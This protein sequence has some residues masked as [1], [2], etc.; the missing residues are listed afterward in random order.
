MAE[1]AFGFVGAAFAGIPGMGVTALTGF[2]IGVT[3]GSLLF[4]QTG[5]PLDKGKLDE[6]RLQAAQQGTPIPIIYGRNRTAGTVLWASGL[7]ETIK[8]T[9]GGKGGG[10]PATNNYTY[11]TSMA[12]LVCEGPVSKI[13]RIWA[14]T[15][16]IY[17]WRTGGSPTWADWIDPTKVKIYDGTQTLPDPTIEAAEGAGNVPAFMDLCY[18]VF[19]DLP[20]A[21]VGNQIPNFLFEVETDWDNLEDVMGDVCQRSGLESTDY[22]FSNLS[23]FPTRG[24][25]IGARTEGGRV[26]EMVG[27]ANRFDVI[28]S[29]GKIKALERSGIPVVDIPVEH[30]GANADGPPSSFVEPTRGQETDIPRSYEVKY[31]SEAQ[32][33]QEFTQPS[34]R[35]LSVRSSQNQESLSFPMSLEDNY[36]KYLADSFLLERWHN[37][38][39]YMLT[40]PY[41][42]LYLDAGDVI[43]VPNEAGGRD[44][45]RIL[46][47]SQGVLAQIEVKATLDDPLL[48]VDP[49][50]GSAG[51]PPGTSAGVSTSGPATLFARECNAL[52]DAQADTP[53]IF[54]A[55]GR[56]SPSWRGGDAQVSPKLQKYGGAYQETIATFAVGSDLGLTDNTALGVLPDGVVGSIDRVSTLKVAM[57]SGSLSSVTEAEMIHNLANMAVVGDEVIQFQTATLVSGSTYTLSNLLRGRRGTEYA[58]NDHVPSEPFVLVNERALNYPYDPRHNG[59]AAQFR[60]I[61]AS[62]DYSGGLPPFS[63][64]ILLESRSRKPYGPV[65]L[66]AAGDRSA[67]SVDVSLTWVR[68]V[69]KNGDLQSL[70]DAPLDEDAE[71]YEV[72]ILDVTATTILRTI[73]G[74]TA[75]THTY[76]VAEQTADGVASSAFVFR[77]YQITTWGGIGRGHASEYKTVPLFPLD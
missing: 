36:A 23:T 18:V 14:N 45:V 72:E 30:I 74:L 41:F 13:R 3:L 65:H 76:S 56:S 63:G 17:D 54:L 61:E 67:G 59:A 48:Y 68:R 34:R 6:I 32:D 26:S 16:V 40:L 37:R 2:Q 49:G 60:L 53:Q 46:E 50:L 5:P 62:R 57:I 75:P 66:R 27:L 39:G 7:K 58:M 73:T 19:E 51:I 24:I 28:E 35:S 10:S 64:A 21:E 33:F 25:V 1:L 38:M 29:G 8:T 52:L 12:L 20:L 9:G 55:A 4:P 71:A 43:T 69:R 47:M 11:T 15:T 22:D 70:I 31:N 77:V 42:Y 44:T